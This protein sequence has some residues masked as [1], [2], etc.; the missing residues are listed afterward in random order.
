MYV[1]TRQ[2]VGI[3]PGDIPLRSELVRKGI[4]LLSLSIPIGYSAVSRETALLILIPL[5]AA[6]VAV[7]ILM[8]WV[9]PVRL[10]FLRWFGFLLRPHE[11]ETDRLLLN[12]ASY[13][14]ISACLCVAIFPKVVAV[15][16]FAVLIIADIASALAG[17]LWGHHRFL[18]KSAEGTLAFF[19]AAT[20][21]VGVTGWLLSAPWTF[22]AAGI[23]SVAVGSLVE[24]ASIR[25]RMDD[26]L[27]IPLS[28]GA[29]LWGLG[30]LAER[31]LGAPFLHLL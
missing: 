16:A 8:H 29:V 21:T 31:L 13:V 5:A 17:K 20:A 14:L 3:A 4:H 19:L 30:W 23:L 27:S 12:G 26:N 6:F 18:D 28:I 11:L 22:F 25:L 24:A 9:R 15:T 10:W 1:G 7:D 2:S